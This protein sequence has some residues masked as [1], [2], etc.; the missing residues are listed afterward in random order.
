L[1]SGFPLSLARSGGRARV[2]PNWQAAAPVERTAH[3]PKRRIGQTQIPTKCR[4]S[5][6]KRR[7][8]RSIVYQA[9]QRQ[10]S[11]ARVLTTSARKP[12]LRT[13]KFRDSLENCCASASDPKIKLRRIWLLRTH[14]SP[15]RPHEQQRKGSTGRNGLIKTGKAQSLP[16]NAPILTEVFGPMWL[17]RGIPP[18]NPTSTRQTENR[19]PAATCVRPRWCLS[20]LPVSA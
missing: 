13:D 5:S 10:S 20:V 17:A 18:A 4:A 2:A 11:I 1:T 3:R 19:N 12:P 9:G 6:A 16:Q 15:K 14:S 8:T 7:A